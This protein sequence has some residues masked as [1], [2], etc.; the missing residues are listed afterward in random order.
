[1]KIFNRDISDVSLDVMH[2]MVNNGFDI[3]KFVREFMNRSNSD[4]DPDPD[5]DFDA[6]KFLFK[7]GG[8]M[9]LTG[10]EYMYD[11]DDV[12]FIDIAIIHNK[13]KGAR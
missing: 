7:N 1:M 3:D 8:N 10:T 5:A 6:V 11:I 13:I 9:N 4:A 2:V 12:K